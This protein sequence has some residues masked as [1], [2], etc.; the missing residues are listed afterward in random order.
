M[1]HAAAYNVMLDAVKNDRLDDVADS[2]KLM[3]RVMEDRPELTDAER[4][5]ARIA[6]D[7]LMRLAYDVRKRF[8]L[9]SELNTTM[10]TII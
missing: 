3:V 5:Q 10:F 2:V 7:I 8:S 4:A 1:K 6:A 9:Q